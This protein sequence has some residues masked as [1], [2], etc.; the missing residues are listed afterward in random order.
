MKLL[1]AVAMATLVV[2]HAFAE[3][4]T[5][6]KGSALTGVVRDSTQAL[7]PGASLKL[8]GSDVVES[9]SDG[10]YHFSCVKNGSHRLAVTMNGFTEKDLTVAAS[11]ESVDVVLLPAEVE[12]QVD[13]SADVVGASTTASGPTMK[14]SGDQLQSLADDPDDLQQQL[15]QLAAAAGGNPSNTTIA[16]DGFQDSSKLPPKSSI[17]YIEVNP[18]QF[19]AEYREPPFDGGRVNV[20]TK[21]GQSTYHGALFL[22][23]GSAWEN[24]RDP[25][26]TSKAAIGKQRYGFELTGPIRKKGSDFS[27]NLEHRAINEF[28][29]VD[30]TTVDAGGNPVET[31]QNVP[32]PQA[33]WV[34]MARMD[35]QL[36]PKNT[37][38]ASYSA[39]VNSQANVGV[40]GTSLA[41]TG[42]ANG[43][44]EHMLRLSNITTIS[45]KTMHEARVSFKWDGMTE[46]P[47]STAPQV[48]VAGAFT[49]GGSQYGAQRTREFNV[50]FDDDAILTPKN[51]TIKFG[52]QMMVYADH[53][54]LPQDFNGSYT[55]GGGTAPVLDANGNATAQTT[56]ITGLQQYQRALLGQPGGSPTA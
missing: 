19:S 18:D 38:I 42:Y 36:G 45:A 43:Q 50:E 26:S 5:V 2:P 27:L 53:Q 11:R 39:N 37:F 9:G 33:L 7:I 54:Q 49:G 14:I 34:G 4:D 30:A 46:T 44:Y 47:S 21:P 48:S 8:D 22:T 1:A 41:E 56:T 51:H 17:A 15:Q 52:T 35:W 24:A 12:T 29:A 20:Y 25:F 31:F 16:V 40:G 10:R 13:V 6:C 3:A 23:N 32:Q 55:F 28:A